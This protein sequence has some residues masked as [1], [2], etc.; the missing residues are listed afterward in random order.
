M[1]LVVLLLGS[2]NP[3]YTPVESTLK[4]LDTLIV[5]DKFNQQFGYSVHSRERS[6]RSL[7]SNHTLDRWITEQ[8]G[9]DRLE[10]IQLF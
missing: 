10:R 4:L 5:L 3:F 2:F 9:E 6:N 1:D 8:K 7:R